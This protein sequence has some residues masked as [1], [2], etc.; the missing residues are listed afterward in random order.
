MANFSFF[1][2]KFP[3][4]QFEACKCINLFEGRKM[5]R[6]P[7]AV[8]ALLQDL[9]P[10]L[11]LGKPGPA[12]FY[13]RS[14][15]DP[16]GD[17]YKVIVSSKP[18]CSCQASGVCV[19]ILFVLHRICKV[20]K[21][22]SLL[23]EDSLSERQIERILSGFYGRKTG[24]AIVLNNLEAKVSDVPRAVSGT[25]IQ[26]PPEGEE[27]PICLNP[28]QPGDD[29]TYCRH[30]CGNNAHIRCMK[31][32]AECNPITS[33]KSG[34]KTTTSCPFC[35]VEW[36]E[37]IVAT[38]ESGTKASLQVRKKKSEFESVPSQTHRDVQCQSCGQ[39]PIYGNCYRCLVCPSVNLCRLCYN[40]HAHSEEKH[41]FVWRPLSEG[42]WLPTP[43]PPGHR[44]RLTGT[45]R[46]LPTELIEDLQNRELEDDDYQTL[47][48]LCNA[49]RAQTLHEH[50]ARTLPHVKT[51][52]CALN[53]KSL[54]SKPQQQLCPHCN[55]DL[56]S[57][58][59]SASSSSDSQNIRFFPSCMH[60]IHYRCALSYFVGNRNPL[61]PFDDCQQPIF[62]G[63]VPKR[64]KK[65]KSK[66]MKSSNSV[67]AKKVEKGN[68]K[69][70]IVI[71]GSSR[72]IQGKL[73][74]SDENENRDVFVVRGDTLTNSGYSGLGAGSMHDM[75]QKEKNLSNF[76]GRK[77][78]AENLKR[79][80]QNEKVRIKDSIVLLTKEE[81][82]AQR[83]AIELQREK[84][85][86]AVWNNDEISESLARLFQRSCRREAK[87]RSRMKS[88]E[89]SYNLSMSRR[90]F[91]RFIRNFASALSEKNKVLSNADSDIIF[92]AVR[93]GNTNRLQFDEFREACVEFC[94]RKGCTIQE[95]IQIAEQNIGKTEKILPNVES[96][97]CNP[98]TSS[99]QTQKKL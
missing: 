73:Q 20:P 37:I 17:K 64:R 28:F 15:E 97:D 47:L 70:E 42:D 71:N 91:S 77:S 13:V 60:M 82:I 99:K 18:S 3:Q 95:I 22:D 79:T 34:I 1:I 63:L 92:N 24:R 61:C 51:Q 32:W 62:P 89:G 56:H 11:L 40:R 66:K 87:A 31:Q 93:M 84:L 81:R 69:L 88:V 38:T 25:V 7:Q 90:E 8:R 46:I 23:W 4:D 36:G 2:P 53:E 96:P 30:G 6:V 9:P 75:R 59:T 52:S 72:W 80:S 57:S 83:E 45:G 50:L 98:I 43:T 55:L 58:W 12:V 94:V 78:G 49:N 48:R 5:R 44:R 27:C 35:R 74:Q 86:I 33:S 39:T 85:Q 26:K 41:G 54:F 67:P 76:L 68:A 29:L 65:K 16:R 19:H 10:C 21:T 14:T